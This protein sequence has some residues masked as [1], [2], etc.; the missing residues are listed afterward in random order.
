MY[1]VRNDR[2]L[3]IFLCYK[4]N[5]KFHDNY[6]AFEKRYL[7]IAKNVLNFLKFFLIL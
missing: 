1:T 6:D 7:K 5:V 4:G 2:K 3:T